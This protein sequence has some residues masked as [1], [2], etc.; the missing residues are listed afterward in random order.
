M[1]DLIFSRQTAGLR[2]WIDTEGFHIVAFLNI[3]TNKESSRL[4][5]I[6]TLV[7]N[8]ERARSWIDF[9]TAA[10]DQKKNTPEF[11][12]PDEFLKDGSIV[13]YP[14]YIGNRE[15]P[16]IIK[17]GMP[18]PREGQYW[19]MAFR[20]GEIGQIIGMIQNYFL[21]EFVKLD[22]THLD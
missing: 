1:S 2:I 17:F 10:R 13:A 8:V 11:W 14:S 20:A 7:E 3:W 22:K 12:F 5:V 9:L 4:D 6:H 15:A 19:G 21:P 18:K 16:V